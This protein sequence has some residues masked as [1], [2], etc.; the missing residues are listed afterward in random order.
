MKLNILTCLTALLT[1]SAVATSCSQEEPGGNAADTG[2]CPMSFRFSMPSSQ[3]RVT[4]N[5]F[6]P[7]DI[8]GIFVSRADMPLAIAGNTVNNGDLTYNGSE[9]TPSRPLYWDNGTYNAYAYYPYTAEIPSVSS[10]PFAVQL[11]QSTAGTASELGGYEASDFLWASARNVVSSASPL[12]MTFRHIMSRVTVKLIKGED[13]EGDLPTDVTVY[14]HNTVPAAT[15]DLAAGIAT[16]EVHGAAATITARSSGNNE[17]DAIVVPQRLSSRVPLVEIVT[18]GVSLL[19]ENRFV[20]RSGIN[21]R[22]NVVLDKDPDQIKIEIGGEI[23]G[24]N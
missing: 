6:E 19:C 7:G 2:R 14:I 18:N 15:I 12:S 22:F 20:F 3:S 13:Y 23:V 11:D 9:W 16:P 10:L 1:A 21:H 8:V 17:Y 24:W 4:D 5:A